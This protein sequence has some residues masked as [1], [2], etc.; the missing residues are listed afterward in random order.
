MLGISTVQSGATVDLS[1]T[2]CM[3]YVTYESF[4]KISNSNRYICK[5]TCLGRFYSANVILI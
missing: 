1:R 2:N 5:F 4:L 3:N